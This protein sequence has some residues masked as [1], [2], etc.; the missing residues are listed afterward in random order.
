MARHKISDD[1]KKPEIG[2]TIDKKLDNVLNEYL[3][4]I[5]ISRSKYIEN[6]IREDFTKKGRIVERDF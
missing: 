1:K 3:N 2:I 5:G 6:L 4:E